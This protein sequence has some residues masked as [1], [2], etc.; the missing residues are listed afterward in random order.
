M[1]LFS[2]LQEAQ[3]YFQME[4]FATTNGMH[5]D[6]LSESKAVCSMDIQDKHLNALNGVMGGATFTLADFASAALTNHLHSPTVAQQVSINYLNGVRGT[7]LIAE[8]SLIKNGKNSMVTH[9]VVRDD[10]QRDIA[11][12][13]L[14]SFKLNPP[15][16]VPSE[17]K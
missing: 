6:E 1:A 11:C 17:A 4:R 14:T 9:V 3:R 15:S 10:L 7:R 12:M 16:A 5:L 8:A 13:T 2:S